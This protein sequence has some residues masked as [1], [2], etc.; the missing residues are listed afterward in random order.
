MKLGAMEAPVPRCS[1]G[2][3]I[4]A[5]GSIQRMRVMQLFG[6]YAA[7]VPLAAGGSFEFQN[8]ECGDYMLIAIGAKGCVTTKVLRA[9]IAGSRADIQIPELNGACVSGK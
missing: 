2:G 3:H 6:S 1:I 5:D 4:A 8:L 9:S 7:D